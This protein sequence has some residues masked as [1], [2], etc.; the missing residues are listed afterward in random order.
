MTMKKRLFLTA[1]IALFTVYQI[2]AQCE[3]DTINCVD[4]ND[5]GQI[6]P[7]EL[8]SGII[9]TPYEQVITLIPPDETIFNET[10]LAL[11]KIIVDSIVNL[12]PGITAVSNAEEF[13]VDEMYC[14]LLSGTPTTPGN[15]P[16]SIYVTPYIIFLDQ[17]VQGPQ[18]VD[19]TSLTIRIGYPVSSNLQL[20]DTRL[21]ISPNP[22]YN[23]S[24]ISYHTSSSG[25]LEL[26]VYDYLGNEMMKRT[27]LCKKG[28]NNFEINIST[29]HQGFYFLVMKDK[30]KIYS[31]KIVKL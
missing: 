2:V 3:P 12:P 6:C 21:S 27:E 4:I 24:T 18:Q 16:L 14:F 17:V 7:V 8:P 28:K 5:P 31:R 1:V 22:T 19:D 29:F 13:F 15:F 26:A 10:T 30:E 9:Q 20:L 25:R 11:E 23:N